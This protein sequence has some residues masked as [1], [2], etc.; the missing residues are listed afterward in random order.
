MND[1]LTEIRG[2]VGSG[3][4]E[5]NLI[6]QDTTFYG[7]DLDPDARGRAMARGCSANCSAR[8]NRSKAIFGCGCWTRIRITGR[9]S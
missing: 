9:M 2:L 3:A 8:F 4:R 6:S 5:I 7:K 1:V